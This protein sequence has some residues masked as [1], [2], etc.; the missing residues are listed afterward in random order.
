VT[1][2]ARAMLAARHNSASADL[3]SYRN[4]WP[5][6]PSPEAMPSPGISSPSSLRNSGR[7]RLGRSRVAEHYSMG[8]VLAQGEH[9]LVVEG[10]HIS[11]NRPH[12]LKLISKNS[13]LKLQQ[14]PQLP[15]ADC[16]RRLS[17][18]VEEVYEGP[19]H[20][21]L[22]MHYGTHELDSEHDLSVAILEALRLLREVMPNT[23]D[24]EDCLCLKAADTAKLM[25]RL[26]AL[27]THLQANLFI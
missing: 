20:V 1:S 26:T 11:T 12:S 23:G 19:N 8:G 13:Q 3:S 18:C 4:S 5:Q 14:H 10:V 21:C 17:Q 6:A 15:K 9:F 27:D 25:H 16:S 2:P 24:S 22:V 7:V